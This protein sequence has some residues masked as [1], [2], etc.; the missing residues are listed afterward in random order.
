MKKRI[1]MFLLSVTVFAPLLG[2]AGRDA[3]AA[4]MDGFISGFEKYSEIGDKY[5][6]LGYLLQ[7]DFE[8]GLA[9]ASVSSMRLYVDW[10]IHLKDGGAAPGSG[11]EDESAGGR[12]TDWDA[13]AALNYASPYP[14]FFE[15]LALKAQGK[16]AEAN[17]CYEKA[18]ANPRFI[19]ALGEELSVI[20]D[21]TSICVRWD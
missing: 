8:Y 14:W 17:E 7:A 3:P 16:E 18:C 2:C 6:E 10:L 1:F 15:S 4:G 19:A 20:A 5:R 9:A 12:L 21:M 13:I 11:A